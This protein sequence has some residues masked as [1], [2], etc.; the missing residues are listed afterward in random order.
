MSTFWYFIFLQ[1][2]SV[3]ANPTN[4]LLHS[5]ENEIT[6]NVI[7][8]SRYIKANAGLTGMYLRIINMTSQ[9]TLKRFVLNTNS[10]LS[11]C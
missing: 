4:H 9:N 10:W 2:K 3:F 1:A 7:F 6:Q 11:V 5:V 8:A